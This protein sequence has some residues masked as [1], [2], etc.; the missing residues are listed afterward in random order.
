[1]N[2]PLS[3]TTSSITLI[4]VSWFVEFSCILMLK[5]ALR[6][7]EAEEITESGLW[8]GRKEERTRNEPRK[9]WKVDSLME[10]ALNIKFY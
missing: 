1:M 8:K 3:L 2:Y 6:L 5:D 10:K 4:K 9:S 7:A